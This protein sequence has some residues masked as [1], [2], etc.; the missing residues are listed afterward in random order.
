MEAHSSL[1]LCV[2]AVLDF[3]LTQSSPLSPGPP[4]PPPRSIEVHRPAQ[5]ALLTYSPLTQPRWR[6]TWRC[7]WWRPAPNEASLGRGLG[8]AARRKSLK[9]SAGGDY[10][11]CTCACTCTILCRY[12]ARSPPSN[13]Y[14]RKQSVFT[15]LPAQMCMVEAGSFIDSVLHRCCQSAGKEATALCPAVPMSRSRRMSA[16]L[17]VDEATR[18]ARR[19]AR[20]QLHFT[21]QPTSWPRCERPAWSH[22]RACRGSTCA[23]RRM[24]G[25]TAILTYN[26]RRRGG[27]GGAARR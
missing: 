26:G 11:T 23:E 10:D 22:A 1:L 6:S 21:R 18:L 8:L 15:P 17:P 12:M 20:R 3:C 19:L 7:T 27:D 14:R 25:E 2:K 5:T 16:P 9:A 24:A 13:Q 4:T